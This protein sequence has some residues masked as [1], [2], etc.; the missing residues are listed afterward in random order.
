MNMPTK[1][2]VAIHGTGKRGKVH[3]E[4]FRKDARFEVVAICGRDRE[5]LDAAALLAGDPEKYQDPAEML[6]ETKPDVFCFCTPPSVRLLL[7][8]LD[9]RHRGTSAL[10]WWATRELRKLP[11]KRCGFQIRNSEA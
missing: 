10:S 3:A 4:T 2:T 5:R 11:A 6:R 7:I 1:Y 9:P 8:R